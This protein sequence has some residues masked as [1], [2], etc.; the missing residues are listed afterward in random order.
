MAVGILPDRGKSYV[1]WF[2]KR[3]EQKKNA[4]NGE[5]PRDDEGISTLLRRDGLALLMFL[6]LVAGAVVWLV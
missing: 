1:R 2:L 5:I 3:L 4:R 6:G